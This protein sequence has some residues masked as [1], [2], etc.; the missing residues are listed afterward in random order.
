MM[1]EWWMR[2]YELEE[3]NRSPM[4]GKKHVF[5]V[6]SVLTTSKHGIPY[7]IRNIHVTGDSL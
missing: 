2:R 4:G 1:D 5:R 6:L 7:C 3:E